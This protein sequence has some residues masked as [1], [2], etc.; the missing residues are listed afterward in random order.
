[1]ICTLH[2]LTPLGSPIPEP[3]AWLSGQD[4]QYP[5]L[6]KAPACM[7]VHSLHYL[8]TLPTQDVQYK[9]Q[10]ST[11]KRGST[12]A[13]VLDTDQPVFPIHLG[14]YPSHLVSGVSIL[15]TKRSRATQSPNESNMNVCCSLA[16]LSSGQRAA[17]SGQWAVGSEQRTAGSEHTCRQQT[18]RQEGAIL[19]GPCLAPAWHHAPAA[20]C[21]I[22]WSGLLPFPKPKAQSPKLAVAAR[23]RPGCRAGVPCGSRGSPH[24]PLASWRPPPPNH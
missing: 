23:A 18:H 5:A 20:D 11:R 1:M 13:N 7:N 17:G 4:R 8:P 15:R 14:V 16:R 3:L 21:Y 2:A 6:S 24:A 9:T 10:G 22:V 19:P 12:G